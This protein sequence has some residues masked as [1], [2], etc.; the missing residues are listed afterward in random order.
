MTTGIQALE[1]VVFVLP[2]YKRVDLWVFDLFLFD[3]ENMSCYGL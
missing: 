3:S 2:R 1:W